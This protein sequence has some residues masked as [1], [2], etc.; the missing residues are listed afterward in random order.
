[1][2]NGCS[3]PNPNGVNRTYDPNPVPNG[4]TP[5]QGDQGTGHTGM[6]GQARGNGNGRQREPTEWITRPDRSSMSTQ[7]NSMI[8][9]QW[10]VAHTMGMGVYRVGVSRVGMGTPYGYGIGR[11]SVHTYGPLMH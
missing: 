5:T 11:H 8:N 6:G 1:M 7:V 4:H 2:A 9:T 10:T 3:G